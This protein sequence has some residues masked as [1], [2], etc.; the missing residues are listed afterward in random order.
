MRALIGSSG[1]GVQVVDDFLAEEAV[2]QLRREVA[3]LHAAG[4]NDQVYGVG[5]WPPKP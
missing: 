5:L 3:A 1:G 2:D 4:A